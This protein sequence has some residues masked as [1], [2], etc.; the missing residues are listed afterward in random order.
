M[1]RRGGYVAGCRVASSLL[2]QRAY[3]AAARETWR[4]CL[5]GMVGGAA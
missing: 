2:V 3:I 4:L 1:S 5:R